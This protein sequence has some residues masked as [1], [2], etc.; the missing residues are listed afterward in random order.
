MKTLQFL[1]ARLGR[2]SRMF[3]VLIVIGGLDG[4]AGFTIPIMLAE[5]GRADNTRLTLGLNLLPRIVLCLVATLALQWSL[6]RWG[7]ALSGWFGN[8]LRLSLFREVEGLSLE[9]LSHHHSG[10]LTSLINQVAGTVGS[11]ATTIIWLIGHLTTTLLLFFIFTARES[12][13]LACV[14]VLFLVMFVAISVILSRRIVPLADTINTTAASLAERFIDFLTNISTVKRLGIIDWA[15][16]K[17]LHETATNNQ[18]IGAFQRFHA[19]RWL[20]LHSIFFTSYLTTIAF[21]IHRIELKSISPSI[22]ILFIAGF[23]TVRGHAER[24]AELIKGLM[25]TGAYVTRLETL[26]K[27]PLSLGRIPVPYFQ[28]LECYDL[29][30]QY[31][32]SHHQILI[33]EFMLRAGDRILITGRSGQGKST[34]LALIANQRQATSGQVLW[35]G[36]PYADYNQSLQHSFALVSQEAELFNLSIRENLTL[37]RPVSDSQLHDLLR[38]LDLTELITNLPA[39]LE[40][41]VGEKALRISAGQKQR[42]NIARALLLNR[43]ILLLDEPTAHLDPTTEAKVLDRLARIEPSTSVVIVSHR[44]DLQTFC[45][46]HYE[47]M[48]GTLRPAG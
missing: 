35:N 40:T 21:L 47:F 28:K 42:I 11:T 6:R 9:A 25:E 44:T 22:L 4:L 8:H 45:S 33:P 37:S 36:L 12:L 5:F 7:E 3:W 34:L 10:Y 23:A 48:D 39:G 24:L 30:F 46:R 2:F 15:V 1:L 31:P 26:L 20:L 43:P 19:N 32:N 18:A 38:S 14:N 16:H 13:T 41:V 17:L 29:K 27:N